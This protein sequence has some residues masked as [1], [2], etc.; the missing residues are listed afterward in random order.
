MTGGRETILLVEDDA[1]V[2][3][4]AHDQLVGLGYMVLTATNGLEAIEAVR[5]RADID[6]LFTDVVMPGGL[7]GRELADVVRRIR[8]NLPVLFTSG[9]SDAITHDGRLDADVLLLSKPYPRADL[10][11]SIRQA[12]AAGSPV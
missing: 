2:R 9:Y 8:P 7:N 11:R 3:G 10:A 4:Y 1:L 6:L 12:L 5:G